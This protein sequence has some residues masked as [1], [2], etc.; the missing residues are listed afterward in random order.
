MSR[1]DGFFM[2]IIDISKLSGGMLQDSGTYSRNGG[3][4]IC[5]WIKFNCIRPH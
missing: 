3:L 4:N 2:D 5:A 1:H